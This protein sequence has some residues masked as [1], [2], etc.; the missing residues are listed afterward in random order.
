MQ[1]ARGTRRTTTGKSA[2]RH[3]HPDADQQV[4]LPQRFTSRLVG[5]H[6]FGSKAYK[7]IGTPYS[8]GLDTIR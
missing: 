3:L 4:I 1:S 6:T 2:S 5:A 8:F 7:G